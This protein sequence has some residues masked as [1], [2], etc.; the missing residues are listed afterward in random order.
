MYLKLILKLLYLN[1]VTY[2][3]QVAITA[4]DTKRDNFAIQ[5]LKH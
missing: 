1:F 5:I 3:N 2:Y 4:T